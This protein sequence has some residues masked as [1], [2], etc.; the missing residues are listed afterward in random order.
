MRIYQNK[1]KPPNPP[2]PPKKNQKKKKPQ[3][4]CLAK[5]M[6]LLSNN[7][8]SM[9]DRCRVVA[10]L[11]RMQKVGCSNSGRCRLKR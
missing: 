1:K 11:H 9:L 2:P 5:A 6:Y 4:D 3:T 7:Y 8:V 10:Q